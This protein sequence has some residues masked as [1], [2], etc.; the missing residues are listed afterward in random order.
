MKRSIYLFL[1]LWLPLFTG[2]AWAMNAQMQFSKWQSAMQASEAAQ[3][4]EHPCHEMQPG[5]V[6]EHAT[7]TSNQSHNQHC[8][9]HNCFACGVCIYG[10]NFAAPVVQNVFTPLLSHAKP[11]QFD[12]VFASQL[13]P[14]ALK[15]PIS[16]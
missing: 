4:A 12:K 15:P 14:P 2:S 10:T 3:A 9:G 1:M 8:N 7:Q 11:V 5:Q 13:Y 16:A 6:A